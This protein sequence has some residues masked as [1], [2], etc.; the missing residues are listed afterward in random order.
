MI[1]S[2]FFLVAYRNAEISKEKK[3]GR[4]FCIFPPNTFIYSIR[5]G[6]IPLRLQSPIYNP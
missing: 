3:C 4:K 6:H 1:H 2:S 5:L